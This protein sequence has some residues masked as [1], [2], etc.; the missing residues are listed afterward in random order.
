MSGPSSSPTGRNLQVLLSGTGYNF[1]DSR[2]QARADDLLVR[3]R[4]SG[5]L[6]GAA[7]AVSALEQDFRRRFVP[8]ATRDN[9]FPPAGAMEK[10]RELGRLR[11]RLL[12]LETQIVGMPV[13]TQDKVWWRFRQEENLLHTLLG[14][15][16]DLVQQAE[17][18]T[19][20]ARAL[21]VE[22]WNEVG[23]APELEKTLRALETTIQARRQFLQMPTPY[24]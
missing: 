1:Y 4:A 2:N 19:Q 14:Y 9:P 23:N 12:D 11:T 17:T 15:D 8:A 21:T 18:A 5:A 24:G 7:Q 10:L 6:A 13:P 20:D 16:F 3:Q 22:V